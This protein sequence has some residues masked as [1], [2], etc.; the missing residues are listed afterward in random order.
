[1][2]WKS[3]KELEQLKTLEFENTRSDVE[4]YCD[5]WEKK[6]CQTNHIYQPGAFA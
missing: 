6:T 1:M 4:K 2:K 5:H 3:S